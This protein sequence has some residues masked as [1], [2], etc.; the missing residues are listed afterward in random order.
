MRRAFFLLWGIAFC[1]G[2]Q[3]P[4]KWG[5]IDALGTVRIPER[6]DEIGSFRGDL[7]KGLPLPEFLPGQK[8]AKVVKWMKAEGQE[9][10]K[11]E[12]LAQVELKEPAIPVSATV[13]GMLTKIG[14]LCACVACVCVSVCGVVS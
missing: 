8:G 10:K 4:G 12:P 3:E 7:A 14:V 2:A 13:N 5:M 6:Y 11:N 1:V 9:V